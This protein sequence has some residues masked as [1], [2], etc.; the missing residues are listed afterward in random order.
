[1]QDKN[2]PIGIGVITKYVGGERDSGPV[3]TW[4][5]LKLMQ[6]NGAEIMS[7]THEHRNSTELTPEE[8]DE[9]LRK[10]RQALIENGFIVDGL[11]YPYNANNSGTNKI[12]KK[13]FK[14]AYAKNGPRNQGQGA[15]FPLFDNYSIARIAIGSYF[16]IPESGFPSD[17]TSLEYYKARV[18]WCIDNDSLGAFVLH[19]NPPEFNTTQQQYVKD[20]IDYIRSKGYDIVS[21]REA[22]EI[23]GNIMQIGDHTTDDRFIIDAE[24]KVYNRRMNIKTDAFNEHTVADDI[25]DF[26][27]EVTY[28]PISLAESQ[29]GD[30]PIRRGGILTTFRLSSSSNNIVQYYDPI[31]APERVSFKR[32]VSGGTW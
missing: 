23:H 14:Y 29:S 22:F 4:D 2:I 24:N 16:D 27:Q 9:D 25:E 18:D 12:A 28:T 21:P 13:Y 20:I 30:Y 1:M 3:M 15:N 17:T 32:I 19:S 5:D 26:E 6:K 8:L 7:H 11:I 10:S 31:N